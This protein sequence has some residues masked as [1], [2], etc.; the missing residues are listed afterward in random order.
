MFSRFVLAFAMF[1][2]LGNR[3]KQTEIEP[4]NNWFYATETGTLPA[5]FQQT[6]C[7]TSVA[8]NEDWWKI[9]LD[10]H[11]NWYCEGEARLIVRSKGQAWPFQLRLYQKYNGGWKYFGTWFAVNGY[12]DT[13]DIGIEYYK[14]GGLDDLY[15]CVSNP[16][17]TADYYLS[18]F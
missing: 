10:F 15:V 9:N 17:G 6:V 13:G 18:F 8:G 4:N 3:C 12:I 14:P 2:A 1:L 7:G 16:M 11:T 5:E